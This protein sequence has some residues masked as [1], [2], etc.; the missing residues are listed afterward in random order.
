M[1][2]AST[3]IQTFTPPIPNG[4][5]GR[6]HGGHPRFEVAMTRDAL[7]IEIPLST[8]TYPSRNH[9]LG[10][11]R[12]YSAK[13]N[14]YKILFRA[15]VDA[16]IC[17][18]EHGWQTIDTPCDFSVTRYCSDFRVRDAM[19]LGGCEA[20]ALTQGLAWTDDT[21]G[22]PAHVDIQIDPD[23]YDRVLIILRRQY[24]RDREPRA[25]R[26]ITRKRKRGR[27]RDSSA[28]LAS[29][30]SDGRQAELNGKPVSE[31]EKQ[32]LLKTY[33]ES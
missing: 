4:D 21:L 16:A 12:R 17:A 11:G 25:A 14:A 29:G 33:L 32:K 18:R 8:T 22:A 19:N 1:S 27:S 30:A 2:A 5:V 9:E 28:V 7:M 13:S 26:P 6:K 15:V 24:S 23:G 31:N 10:G 20:N 3:L